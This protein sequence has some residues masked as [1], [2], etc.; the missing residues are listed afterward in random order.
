MSRQQLTLGVFGFGCVGYGLWQVL[1]KTPGLKAQIKKIGVKNKD[2]KRPFEGAP[3]TFNP[4]DILLDPEINLV[5]ELIDDSEAAF[6]IVKRAL[7]QRK[8]VVSANKK[9]IAEHLD[10]L[11][12]LQ[13][14]YQTPLL[15]EAAVCASIP[16]IR[17]LEEYYDNDLLE[18]IEGIVNGSTNYILTQIS[19]HKIPYEQALLEAQE[20]GFAESNPKLDVEGWDSKYKL[21]LL[22]AHAFGTTLP[23][24]S[25]YHF[26]IERLGKQAF[27]YAQEKGLE[28]KLIASAQKIDDQ[29]LNAWVIPQ[30]VLKDQLLGQ[31]KNEYNGVR[32]QTCFSENQF[33][34][35]KGAGAYPTASAVISDISALSYQYRYEYKKRKQA[36]GFEI[37]NTRNIHVFIQVQ[38]DD[39]T[40]VAS[41]FHSLDVTHLSDEGGYLIGYIPL[42][43][44]WNLYQT[45]PIA[46]VMMEE[47]NTL[48]SPSIR[49]EIP[50]GRHQLIRFAFRNKPRRW[51]NE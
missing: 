9:M 28:I 37:D 17:N 3:L 47:G 29:K 8:A 49:P 42:Q 46:V 33:F 22:I 25:I 38:T 26:G 5:V 4:D 7:Q 51:P 2:K 21:I 10:E 6:D 45:L 15:Y 44:L 18:R 13:E 34:L 36:I 27:E 24:A 14:K 16:I 32:T 40:K 39:L 12:E 23:P 11:I 43:Q 48:T 19:A 30:F 41:Y 50:A 35:G 20:K 31:V 1:E